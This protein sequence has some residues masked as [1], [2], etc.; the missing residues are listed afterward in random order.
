[1]YLNKDLEKVSQAHDPSSGHFVQYQIG[2]EF[3]VRF[4]TQPV[5]IEWLSSFLYPWFVYL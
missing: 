2:E 1:M 3:H 4:S 5:E